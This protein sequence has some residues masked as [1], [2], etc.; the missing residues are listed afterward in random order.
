MAAAINKAGR[1]RMLCQRI[2]KAYLQIGQ[3]I[4]TER[5]RQIMD[6][7]IALFDRQLVELEN[8]APTPAI[9][10]TYRKLQTAWLTYKDVLEGAAPN[11]TG[12]RRV[13]E[14]SEVVL[15]LAQEGTAQLERYSGKPSMHVVNVAGR[16]RMLS[17]RIGRDYQALSWGIGGGETT[18]DSALARAE[19]I[20]AQ[21][22]LAKAAGNA[23]AL[24]EAL[25]V[26]NRQWI[27]FDAAIAHIGDRREYYGTDVAEASELILQGMEDVVR[28]AEQTN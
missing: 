22:D 14:L 10:E 13:L 2:A 28:L 23:P 20:A 4:D 8:Y 21:G 7:S 18:R 9:R 25:Q 19:F 16:Q 11:Q 1:E 15:D 17:Q 3:N 5:S 12:G 6:A 26:V 27:F 24:R